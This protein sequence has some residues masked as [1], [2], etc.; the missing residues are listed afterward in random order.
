MAF[1]HLHLHTEY[2]LLDGACRIEPLLDR[3]KALGQTSVAITDH[4]VMYGVVNF[5]KAAKARGIKPIIGCEIYVAK[6]GMTDKVHGIDNENRH[7]V[8]LCK[9]ETGYRNLVAIVS[10]AWTEGFYNKPRADFDLLREHSEGLIALSACLAGEI[11]RALSVGA[12]DSA[13]E[14]ALRYREIF[15]AENFYLELQDHG[16]ENQAYVNPQLIRLSRETGIP[17]VVTNDCHY[18]R[19]EDTKMHHILVCIQTNRT[20]EDEDTLEFGSDEFYFKSEEEMRALFPDCPEAADNT[21]IIA[22]RCNLEFEFGHTKLPRFDTPDG[23]D[24]RDYFRRMCYDGLHRH[25]GEHP[26][27]SI[28]DR[29]EYE[30]STIDTMGYVNYYLIVYD[31]IR[32]AKSM[33][34]PVGPGR[35]SG[36]GSLAAYC[37]GITGVDPL[38]YD[39]LFERF[40]NPERVSMPDFDIDFS[41]ERRQEIIE[42]V[43]DKYGADHVA[44]I[45]TFGTMAARLAIRDVGRAMAIPYNVCDAVA[46]LVP[47]ELNMT[48]DH[49][50]ESV[51]EL[52]DKYESDEQVHEL[53]DMARKIEGMPRHT[54]THAAGVV[55]TDRPVMDYVPLS[56]NDESV[57]TQFTMT[58]IEELGLLK[59]DFLGLRNLSVIDNAEKMIQKHVPGFRVE[60]A[61]DDDPAVFAMITSGATEGVFQFESAGMRRVIMQSEPESIEDLIAVISL[62]RPG[63]MKFIPTYIENRKHPEKITYRHPRLSKIL[64]VTCG[65]ILYQEQVMRIFR[66]LAGY[67]LGRADIVRRA[68]SK[69]KHKVMAEE[70]EYFIHGLKR[71]DG[72]VEIEGCV[73]RGVDERTAEIIYDE[74]ESFASYAFNKSHAAAYAVVAYRTAYLKYHYPKEYMAA[75]LTSVLGSSGKVAAYMEECGRLGIEVLPPHVNE[76]ELGFSV[77]K[78][79]I[80]F[81]LLAIKNL[82]RGVIQRL[83]QERRGGK[84][85]NLYDFCKRMQG[86][87]LNR[88]AVESLIRCGAFDGLGSNRR[89]MLMAV[90]PILDQLDSDKRRNVEGQIGLF[91]FGAAEQSDSYEMPHAEEY[92]QAELLTMEKEVTG[93]YLSGHPMAPYA[94]VYRRDLVARMDE[95]AQSAAGESDKYRDEQYVDVLAIVADIKKKATKSG[96]NMAFVTLE[97]IYGSMEAL[98]FPKVLERY[99]DLL[100]VGGAVKAHGRISFTE[101]KDPKLICEYLA[102][103]FSPGEM[104]AQGGRTVDNRPAP[105]PRAER[106]QVQIKGYNTAYRGL[107]LRVPSASHPLCRKALQYVEVFDGITDLYLYYMDE[108]KLVRAPAKYRVAV[109]YELVAALK[110][111]LGEENVALKEV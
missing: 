20:V 37:I 82:G 16:L 85:K 28:I 79:R 68:M 81:G 5:Y 65:C 106:Q 62:Y 101:E 110:K 59:M 6:R 93:M 60:N 111:L 89:E 97:D 102:A 8:L 49:A 51:T 86:R 52:R 107:Y 77:S 57:V 27:Q 2:S 14:A 45:V 64:D 71:A 58:E 56:M 47:M 105:P 21:Q 63:P 23:S 1:T 95:I 53:I 84:F 32:Q 104:L 48:L 3:A 46:K 24:N 19:K 9:N 61:P 90:G 26:Q 39:L 29:L 88:R 22:D 100:T 103:P 98:V 10:K 91:D 11:P 50:L 83:L 25:Y 31:F 87:D 30:I 109:N 80:R 69:K 92:P 44:Q 74:M 54:S 73:A 13:K 40:L 33:G 108:K 67:S 7:L 70:R 55:I 35:G 42:Y 99:S 41:D 76:S 66:E 12:Y 15:G 36:V 4:G 78:D 43:V 38:R 34:I 94:E 72:T 18:I 17:L 75:L 96:A